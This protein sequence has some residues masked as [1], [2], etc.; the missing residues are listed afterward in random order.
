MLSI[1]NLIKSRAIKPLYILNS[2]NDIK[3]FRKNLE[4]STEKKFIEYQK[5]KIQ[6][7][8]RVRLYVLD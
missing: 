4:D 2:K 3:E 8:T 5:T 7:Q 1:K 6:N